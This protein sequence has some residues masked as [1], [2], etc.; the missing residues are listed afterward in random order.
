MCS[1]VYERHWTG[2]HTGVIID[3]V[4][5]YTLLALVDGA[6]I[7]EIGTGCASEAIGVC[8]DGALLQTLVVVEQVVW[9]DGVAETLLADED[10]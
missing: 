3:I 9:R 8:R 4:P 5:I 6:N 7:A 2:I 10:C 1:I